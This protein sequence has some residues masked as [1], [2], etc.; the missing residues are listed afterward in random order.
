MGWNHLTDYI[1]VRNFFTP[2][3]LK[4]KSYDSEGIRL[5][6]YNVRAF[7]VFDWVDDPEVK[8]NIFNLIQSE[9]PDIIC[10]QE[11]YTENTKTHLAD[12]VNRVFKATPYH[13]LQYTSMGG[14]NSGYGMATYSR[15][16]VIEKGSIRFSNTS[17][18]AIFTDLVFNSDTVRIYNIH[19]QSIKFHQ[20][21][22]DFIDSLRFRYDEKQF[23]ELRDITL[24]LKTAFIKRSIQ[25]DSLSA[26]MKSSPYPVIVCGDFNDTPVSYAYRKMR[27]GLHDSFV[28][29]GAG[30]GNTYLG[31]FP[32]FRI[33]YVLHS[34]EFETIGF[35]R[36]KAKLSDH[37]PIIC[38]LQYVQGR[39]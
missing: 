11:Y 6:S 36:V 34:S 20:R 21:N 18:M 9:K 15:Y 39:E 10:L 16:P 24:R 17:N 1:P 3:H 32:S 35:E 5:L 31:V 8:N 25:V 38:H 27:S 12:R 28:S 23:E 14:G 7:N 26:H 29:T 37:Y 33:D 30:T 4:G 2:A 13:H 22:Y 19:L